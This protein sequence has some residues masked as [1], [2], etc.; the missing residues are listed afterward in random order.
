[1]GKV[2]VKLLGFAS[3]KLADSF[4]H[5]GNQILNCDPQYRLAML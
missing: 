3:E 1:M 4:L 5:F 2:T